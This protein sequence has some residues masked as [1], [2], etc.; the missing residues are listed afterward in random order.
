MFFDDE[1]AYIISSDT[2]MITVINRYTFE[3]VGRINSGLSAPMYGIVKNRKA[4]VTNLADPDS[5]EDDYLAII[6]TESL[7]TRRK[8]VVGDYAEYITEDSGLFYIKSSI[9]GA[10]SNISIFDPASNAVISRI[11]AKQGYDSFEIEG[12]TIYVMSAAGLQK[13]DKTTGTVR[14]ETVFSAIHAGASNIDIEDRTIYFTAGASVYTLPLVTTEGPGEPVLTYNRNSEEGT[15]NI[16]EVENERIFIADD[17]ESS[18]IEVYTTGGE[19][20]QQIQ[21]GVEPGGFY[22]ND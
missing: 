13:I 1:N 9:S 21:V 4:Y 8:I 18:Y 19:F 6:D 2:S 10:G 20:V 11:T 14:S 12:N 7:Q 15:I 22:F 17:G 3:L 5:N 16:F